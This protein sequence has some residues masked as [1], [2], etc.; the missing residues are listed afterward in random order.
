MNGKEELYVED[1]E[2]Q[3]AEQAKTIEYLRACNERQYTMIMELGGPIDLLVEVLQ[4]EV[5]KT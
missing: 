4:D 5:T 1:L 3:L 2:G